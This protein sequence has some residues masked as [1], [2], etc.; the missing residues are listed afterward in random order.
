MSFYIFDAQ[1]RMF[2]HDE[3]KWTDDFYEAAAFS[4]RNEAEDVV[5]SHEFLQGAYVFDDGIEQ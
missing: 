4:T 2:L 5:N 1:Q 3:V